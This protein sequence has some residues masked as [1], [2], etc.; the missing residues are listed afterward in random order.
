VWVC[1]RDAGPTI[2]VA[3]V[4]EDALGSRLNHANPALAAA[5]VADNRELLG[6]LSAHASVR[7]RYGYRR[8]HILVAREGIVANRK[9][10]HRRVLRGRHAGEGAEIL[11][12]L[13][14]WG[15]RA[16]AHRCEL[17]QKPAHG[18]EDWRRGWSLRARF[19]KSH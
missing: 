16:T 12:E 4:G 6:R 14:S 8:L 15:L 9:R 10:V 11:Q 2:G 1:V 18:G 5:P 19:K 3:E 13:L 17:P 7:A